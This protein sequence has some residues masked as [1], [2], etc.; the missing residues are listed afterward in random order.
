M[1]S[2]RPEDHPRLHSAHTSL[3]YRGLSRQ[4]LL[5]P[6]QHTSGPQLHWA[7][8]ANQLPSHQCL[9]TTSFSQGAAVSEDNLHLNVPVS[10][11][12]LS[13]GAVK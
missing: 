13:S 7:G 10:A 2:L 1:Y 3:A 6:P 4:H 5:L 12:T 9:R 8:T 11:K